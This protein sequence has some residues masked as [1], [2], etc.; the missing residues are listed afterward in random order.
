MYM[1]EEEIK[2]ATAAAL[3]AWRT[4]AGLTQTEA[5]ARAHTTQENISRWENALVT[6]NVTNVVMLAAAYN[7]PEA[8]PG[9]SNAV[10]QAQALLGGE[11]AA[12]QPQPS[13]V[14]VKRPSR[15]SSR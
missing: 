1:K 4:T 13:P 6:P 15:R 11:D 3:K 9:L 12:W 14:P 7:T 8:L 10:T 5:A 2:R